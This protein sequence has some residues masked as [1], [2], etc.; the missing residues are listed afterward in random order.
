MAIIFDAGKTKE[1][2]IRWIRG[3]FDENGNGCRAV[4]GLSGGKDSGVT[5]AL[6]VKALGADRV[7]GVMMPCGFQKDMHVAEELAALLAIEHCVVNI[8]GG[9]RSIFAAISEGGLSLS[10]QAK[11]NTPAR[12]R[13]TV[14]YAVSAIVNGRV[15]NTCNLSEDWVG[16][17]TKFGDGAGDFSPLSHL[18]VT[19]VKAIG[20]ELGLPPGIID[21]TPEDGLSGLS[22]EENLGFTYDVLDR[23]IREGICEEPAVKEKIDRLNKINSHKLNPIPCYKYN[24]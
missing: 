11:I 12:V 20:R 7:Y 1:E 6:C 23:Y 10:E 3:Y 21:K 4:V 19:E 22:D 9:V 17:A 2:I 5:A 14:L 8:E 15:A 13:M 18:T 24:G 16:Y